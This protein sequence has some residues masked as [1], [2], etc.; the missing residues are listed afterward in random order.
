MRDWFPSDDSDVKF[1]GGTD[2]ANDFFEYV[3]LNNEHK[4]KW[5]DRSD[6]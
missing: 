3:Y 4:E 5:V 2:L 1:S 6:T